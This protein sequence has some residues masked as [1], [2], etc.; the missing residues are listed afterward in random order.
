MRIDLESLMKGERV[1]IRVL[2]N[3]M[4][5]AVGDSQVSYETII[6]YGKPT[7]TRIYIISYARISYKYLCI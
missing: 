7:L 6:T 5:F 1:S 4:P 3:P 2:G